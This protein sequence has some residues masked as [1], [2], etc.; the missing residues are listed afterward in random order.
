[1]KRC[2]IAGG[3]G[4]IGANLAQRLV[5]LGME[6]HVMVAPATDLWRLHELLYMIEIHRADM[7]DATAVNAVVNRIKPQL[8]F[9][10]LSYGGLV[11]QNDKDRIYD[12]NFQGTVNLLSACK[13]VGFDCFVT[14]GSAEEYGYRPGLMGEDS[15]LLPRTHYGVAKAA[16]TL[17]CLREAMEN[18][19]PIY[20]VRPFTTYGDFEARSKLVGS[21][22]VGALKQVPT[23]LISPEASRDFIYIEDLIDLFLLIVRRKPHNRHV[24]NAGTG[25]VTR[26]ADVVEEVRSLWPTQLD[27]RWDTRGDTEQLN[28]T[29]RCADTTNARKW[30]G[31]APRYTLREGLA[32]SAKWF[33]KNAYLYDAGD[34]DREFMMS[35]L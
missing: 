21:L 14:T 27:V 31:W 32:K 1:M 18:D 33:T 29:S 16:S 17:Y 19:L 26:V 24:Y 9:N 6:V 28:G 25:I 15:V 34:S 22:M 23:Y 2:L 3:A 35:I 4:F 10:T 13:K 30:L 11:H 5:K 12:T 20:V 7:S 8:V